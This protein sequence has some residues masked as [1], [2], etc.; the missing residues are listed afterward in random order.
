MTLRNTTNTYG[1]VAKI[2]HWLI[3]LFVLG[4]LTFGFLL[5][6]IPK[7][8]QGLAYNIH[9]VNGLIVLALMII[10]I[11]WRSVNVK[12]LLPIDTQPWERFA[13][14]TV[15]FLLYVTLILMPLSGWI[16]SSSAGKPP[17]IGDL[18]L[19]LPIEKNKA[20]IS[21]AFELHE[22]L[23]YAIIALVTIHVLAALFHYLFRRDNVL[24]R[25]LPDSWVR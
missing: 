16:G 21:S 15:H 23:A 2:L 20:L 9:K 3:F 24:Q 8:Y 17:H 6:S 11:L 13:E 7:P 19:G 22:Y 4:M 25:M 14:Q 1:S 10:R 12:P 5:D 18:A